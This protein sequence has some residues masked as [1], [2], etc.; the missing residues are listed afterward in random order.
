[1]EGVAVSVR[2]RGLVLA[3]VLVVTFIAAVIAPVAAQRE[4]R[5]GSGRNRNRAEA[6]NPM[7]GPT[8]DRFTLA[9]GGRTVHDNLL[10]VTWLLD[11]NVGK[12]EC[13]NVPNVGAGG[14]MDWSTA[15]ACLQQLNSGGGLLGHTTWQMPATPRE[16]AT[17]RARGQHGNSFGENCSGSAYGSLYYFAWK[18]HFGETVALEIGPTRNGFSNLQPTLYWFGNSLQ[19]QAGRNKRNRYSGYN[20]FSFSNGWQGAN[21]DHHVM[22]FLPM[23]AGP[24]PPGSAAAQ[25]TIWDPTA[26]SGVPGQTGVS[27]LANA[28]ISRDPGFLQQVKA[29][30]LAIGKDGSMDQKTAQQLIG[31]MHT[32][33]YLGRGDWKLPVASATHCNI[34]GKTGGAAGFGCDVSGLGHLYYDVFKLGSGAAVADPPDIA[35]VKPFFEVEP[36]L[37]WAC[38]AGPTSAANSQGG[39]LCG[40]PPT[41]EAGFGFSFDM[42]SGFT[43]TTVNGSELYLMVYYPDPTSTKCSTPMQC[44]TQ[45]GG[46][47]SG[48]KCQ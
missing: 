28:N 45:S 46:T 19:Q 29:G 1:M 23:I 41:A 14:G 33:Q 4:R 26:E 40:A 17:C 25:A 21:V 32:S 30:S 48:G 44:C 11:A 38:A 20:S 24:L 31:L 6:K 27:W 16:D 42:G 8:G 22:Y 47:W 3:V 10:K 7:P 37:Y 36:S 5:P 9:D 12:S 2:R 35:E 43:D 15:W 34:K 13:K 39:N 18:R